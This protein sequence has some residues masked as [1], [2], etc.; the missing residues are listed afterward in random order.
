MAYIEGQVALN[1]DAV[2]VKIADLRANMVTR[3]K[4]AKYRAALEYL[5]ALAS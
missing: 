2:F 1:P 5:E 3:P 4:S